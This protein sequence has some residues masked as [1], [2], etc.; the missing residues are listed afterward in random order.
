MAMHAQ[1]PHAVLAFFYQSDSSREQATGTHRN[2]LEAF[3]VS[4]EACPLVQLRLD[5]EQ[6]FARPSAL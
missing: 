4:E 5:A 6:P 2:F 3:G 1:M